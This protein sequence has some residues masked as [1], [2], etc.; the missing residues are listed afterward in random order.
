MMKTRTIF[1]F[2]DFYLVIIFFLISFAASSQVVIE[3]KTTKAQ[4]SKGN[5]PCYVVQIP[6]AELKTVQQNWIKKLQEGNKSKVKELNQELVFIGAAKPELIADSINIYSIL[7]QADSAIALNVFVEIDSA[8]FGPSE[9]KTLLANDK[10]DNDIK[11]YVRDFAVAQYRLAVEDELELEQKNLKTLENDLEKLE[12]EEDNLKKD[13]SSLENDIEDSER[14]I[15]EIGRNITLKDQEIQTH[16]TSIL[17]LSTDV[18]KKA[19]QEKQKQLEKE[20]KGLEKDQ[21]KARD[22]ISSCK[23]KI[24]KNEKAIKDSEEQQNLKKDEIASQTNVVDQV[25]VKLNGIK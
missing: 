18:E 10:I 12:K 14:E 5:Q 2:S 21:G 8:F 17:S 13:N 25:Q 16:N 4:M 7:I 3:V 20:K 19:A 22:N 6:Q 9:D 24:E 11:K 23:S 15:N 1:S